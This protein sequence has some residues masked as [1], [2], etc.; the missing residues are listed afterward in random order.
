[1]SA[2]IGKATNA[3][4]IDFKGITVPQVTELRRHVRDTGSSYLVVKNTLA[5]IAIKDSPMI[6]LRD[7]L[8]TDRRVL[9]T[10]DAFALAKV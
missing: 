5:L 6:E 3:F 9:P 1:M 7:N 10:S 2:G 4:L 8:R